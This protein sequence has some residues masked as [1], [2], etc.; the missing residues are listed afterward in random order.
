MDKQGHETYVEF[1]QEI[2]FL[3]PNLVIA[4]AIWLN[5]KELAILKEHDV[6]IVTNPCANLKLTTGVFPFTN[7][8]N[9]GITIGIGTD[10]V[11]SNNNFDLFEEIKFLALLEKSR[12]N[13]PTVASSP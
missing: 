7:V 5:D 6:K 1:L 13:D 11:A 3:G 10:G 9:H 12:M 2:G 8:R 4:H